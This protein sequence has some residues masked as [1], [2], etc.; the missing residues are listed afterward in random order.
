MQARRLLPIAAILLLVVAG[1]P[2]YR[3]LL[4]VKAEIVLPV[5]EGCALH[6][7]DC[8]AS[9]PQGGK[10][11]FAINPR[12]PSPTDPLHLQVSFEQLEPQV[13]GVRF[14][15]VDMNMGYLEHYV[16][17]LHKNETAGKTVSFS[18][19]AGVFVCSSDLMQWLVL[20]KVQIGE[21]RYEVPFRFETRQ[22]G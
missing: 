15:G 13:V 2:G 1:L 21:T 4:G 5:V 17:D 9:F 8:S 20:V 11:T 10:M 22:Q 14:K 6:L 19:D 7:E 12:Q 16:Y 3:F 18:G